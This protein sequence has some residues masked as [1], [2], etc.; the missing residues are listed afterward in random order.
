MVVIV[1]SIGDNTIEEYAWSFLENGVSVKGQKQRCA[2]SLAINE[3][4]RI[5]VGYGLKVRFPICKRG[6]IQDNYLI[7]YLAEGNFDM[8]IILLTEFWQ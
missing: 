3:K 5:E 1:P 2:S 6:R 8:A 4:I 7:P